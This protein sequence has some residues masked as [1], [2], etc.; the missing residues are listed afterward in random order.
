[1]RCELF[2]YTRLGHVPYERHTSS[3]R[4]L[5]ASSCVLNLHVAFIAG[6]AVAARHAVL[7]DCCQAPGDAAIV[8]PR[9]LSSSS[10]NLCVLRGPLSV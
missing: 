4:L 1:M 7:A 3:H 6:K 9:S 10:L 8:L 2:K 5:V